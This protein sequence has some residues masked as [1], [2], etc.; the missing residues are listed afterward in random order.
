MD[1][2]EIIKQHVKKYTNMVNEQ[3]KQSDTID[4]IKN[5]SLENVKKTA[6]ELAVKWSLEPELD[7]TQEAVQKLLAVSSITVISSAWHP[8]SPE[9]A[10]KEIP[11]GGAIPIEFIPYEVAIEINYPNSFPVQFCVGINWEKYPTEPIG[12][13]MVTSISREYH[14]FSVLDANRNVESYHKGIY[15]AIAKAMV[16]FAEHKSQE[17]PTW[18]SDEER[19]A[20][21]SPI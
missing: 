10:K 7:D 6:I 2:D 15:S 18:V 9:D 16:L 11:I 20:I 14:P 3:K 8:M 13:K 12:Y 19:Y 21:Q 17:M 4:R 1:L 5:E